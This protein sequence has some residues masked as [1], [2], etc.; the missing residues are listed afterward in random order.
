MIDRIDQN[1]CLAQRVDQAII[2]IDM[3][4]LFFASF[5]KIHTGKS[6]TWSPVSLMSTLL[7]LQFE[8]PWSLAL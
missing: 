5:V 7:L 8:C 6:A 4:I 2:Y 1:C 3:I